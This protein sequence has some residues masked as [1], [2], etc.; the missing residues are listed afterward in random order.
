[1]PNVDAV[2]I[3]TRPGRIA[4][5]SAAVRS[6]DATAT[7]GPTSGMNEIRLDDAGEAGPYYGLRLRPRPFL[8][9]SSFLLV[10]RC[11]W[12]GSHPMTLVPHY[13]ANDGRHFLN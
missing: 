9:P 1:M 13:I 7:T 4:S 2:A 11:S 10:R 6:A 5:R 8:R 3:A 12:E